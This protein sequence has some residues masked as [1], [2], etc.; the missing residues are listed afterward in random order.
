VN[1][2]YDIFDFGRRRAEVRQQEV[3]LRKAAENLERLKDEV[4]VQVDR[5][6]NKLQR[7]K[8]MVE[9]AEQLV[10]LR[11]EGERLASN[12]FHQGVVLVSERRKAGAEVYKAQA[13]LMQASLAYLLARVEL[14]R[15]LGVVSQF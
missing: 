9:V 13:D 5:T 10:A 8:N 15:T 4:A 11:S 14:D 1:L 12:Q 3:Q 7:T 6:Y 2:T